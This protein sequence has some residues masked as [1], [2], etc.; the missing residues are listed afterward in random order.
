MFLLD[1]FFIYISNVIPFPC[2]TPRSPLSHPPSPASMRVFLYLPTHSHIPTLSSSTLGHLWRFHRTKDL[3]THRCMAR[4]FI[5]YNICSRSHVY[6]FIDDL[7]P[8]CSW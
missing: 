1:I 4:L 7:V 8:G 6:P 2:F 5:L 3:S